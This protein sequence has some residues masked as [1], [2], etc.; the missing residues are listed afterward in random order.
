[1]I[2]AA[3]IGVSRFTP[4]VN[5]PEVAIL[6]VTRARPVPTQNSDGGIALRQMLSLS[7]DYDHSVI[8]G[9]DAARVCPFIAEQLASPDLFE[10]VAR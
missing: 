10:R 9:A 7:P 3:H 2:C 4:I 1:M 5:A 8:N 6:R